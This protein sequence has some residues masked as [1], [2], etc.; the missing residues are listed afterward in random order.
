M[1]DEAGLSGDEESTT[2]EISSVHKHFTEKHTSCRRIFADTN[3]TQ[4]TARKTSTNYYRML[5]KLKTTSV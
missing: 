4:Y 3:Y 2:L 5:I 1:Y